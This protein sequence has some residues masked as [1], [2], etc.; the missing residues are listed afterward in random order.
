MDFT[1]GFVY[2]HI[3]WGNKFPGRTKFNEIIVKFSYTLLTSI[4]SWCRP[5]DQLP[6]VFNEFI[7]HDEYLICYVEI[8]TENSQ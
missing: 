5:T 3:N 2:T 6:R 7:M 4:S 1:V 8:C